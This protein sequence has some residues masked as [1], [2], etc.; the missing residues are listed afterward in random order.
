MID[1]RIRLVALDLDG[2]LVD[3]DLQL[4][5]RVVAAVRAVVER[6]V[7][8]AIVTGRMTTS[9]LPFALQLGLRDPIVGLQ[10][11]VV[12]EMPAAGSTRLGRLV[13]HT[14]LPAEVARDA[15]A[16][17]RGVGL[18][19]HVNRLERMILGADDPRSRDYSDRAFGRTLI[20]PNLD[21]W[22]R[23][24][25]TK[26]ISS[27]PLGL[28]P[29]ALAAARA[30]F[31]GRADATVSDPRYLEFVAPGVHKGRGLRFLARR[32][33]V[34]MRHTVAIGDQVNDLEMLGEA[35]LGIAMASA[36]AEVRAVARAVAPAVQEDGVAVV[37]E[38]LV[39]GGGIPV[40]AG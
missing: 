26:V 36:P 22:L 16:W 20:V 8:V 28:A 6:G 18:S 5:P 40:P 25:V 33:G 2:T 14:P 27:G 31:G 4:S 15:L 37:L 7:H 35:G 24:P 32:L 29:N 9:A 13:L 39:L 1:G 19:P 12:R 23:R 10:G 11:A 3:R 30:A 38:E 17:C 34:E 21:A